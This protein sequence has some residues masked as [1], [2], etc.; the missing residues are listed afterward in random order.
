M[1]TKYQ[2]TVVF[3]LINRYFAQFFIH[4]ITD[5]KESNYIE[6]TCKSDTKEFDY[7]ICISKT[8]SQ[9]TPI[10]LTRMMK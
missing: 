5:L 6:N 2:T 3:I 4:S 1:V 10:T 9:E 8:T 7:F